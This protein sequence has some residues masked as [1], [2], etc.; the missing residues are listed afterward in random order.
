[1]IFGEG[2]KEEFKASPGMLEVELQMPD[3]MLARNAWR[4]PTAGKYNF[5]LPVST[6]NNLVLEKGDRQEGNLLQTVNRIYVDRKIFNK[7]LVNRV[8]KGLKME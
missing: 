7:C 4:S 2:S 1:M 5:R 6:F 8:M 3:G